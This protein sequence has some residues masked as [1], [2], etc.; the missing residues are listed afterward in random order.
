MRSDIGQN[1]RDYVVVV[2]M[3]GSMEGENWHEA[4]QAIHH[5]APFVTKADPEGVTMFFF[6]NSFV[7]FA[8][9]RKTHEVEHHFKSE[10]PGGGTDLAKVLSEVFREHFLI[11]N[12]KTTILCITD[13][14]PNSK[15][16]VVG[17]ISNAAGMIADPSFLTITFIQV[18]ED[19]DA[20]A[21]LHSLRDSSLFRFQI[22]D[23]VTEHVFE[24]EKLSK[25]IARSL[26]GF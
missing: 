13:G 3:S 23:V 15:D 20:T 9:V 7:R 17:V 25:I 5:L 10:S 18:G 8:N 19:P 6:S 21:F 14:E 11:P 2:D 24:S 22:V 1:Q 4:K 12:R 16:D 26:Q